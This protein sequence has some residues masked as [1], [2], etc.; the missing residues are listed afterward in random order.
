MIRLTTELIDY[1]A[2]TEAVRLPGC[3]CVRLT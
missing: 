3:G 1:H 2:L